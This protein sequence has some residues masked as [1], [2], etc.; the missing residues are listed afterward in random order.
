MTNFIDQY[1]RNRCQPGWLHNNL[2][3]SGDCWVYLPCGH[4]HRIV[5]RNNLSTYSNRLFVGIVEKSIRHIVDH[6]AMADNCPCVKLEILNRL[7]DLHLG[8][9]DRFSAV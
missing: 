6:S 8:S 5:P 2:T 3:T 9:T 1:S 4:H 7:I